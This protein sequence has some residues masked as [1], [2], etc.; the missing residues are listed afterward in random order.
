MKCSAKVG[1]DVDLDAPIRDLR[2]SEKQLVEIAKA[3]AQR[4]TVL[5][6]DEPTASL[7]QRETE[8]LFQIIESFAKDGRRHSICFAST[9]GGEAARASDHNIA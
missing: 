7:T 9:G 1:A 6:L 8:R 2:V 4:V 3:I 5:I